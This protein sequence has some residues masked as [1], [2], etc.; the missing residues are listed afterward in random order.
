MVKGQ[1]AGSPTAIMDLH[2]GLRIAYVHYCQVPVGQGMQAFDI[3]VPKM[4]HSQFIKLL[5]DVGV[6]EPEG[7]RNVAHGTLVWVFH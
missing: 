5:Q 1:I 7:E 3:N 2:P 4:S 6:A